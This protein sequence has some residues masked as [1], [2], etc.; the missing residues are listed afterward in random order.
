MRE[1]RFGQP[2]VAYMQGI[3]V[4]E[5]HEQALHWLRLA[6]SYGVQEATPQITALLADGEGAIA[7]L[8]LTGFGREGPAY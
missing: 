8:D 5:D 3:G 1:R 2:G 4:P 6:E 7:D